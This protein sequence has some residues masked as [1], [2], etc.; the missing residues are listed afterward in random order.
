MSRFLGYRKWSMGVLGLAL[1]FGAA[2]F[3]R[4][5]PELAGVIGTIVTGFFAAN[6]YTTGKGNEAR[7]D[8]TGSTLQEQ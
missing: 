2:M 1:S 4:L 7:P 6:G 3:G 8:S 5:T